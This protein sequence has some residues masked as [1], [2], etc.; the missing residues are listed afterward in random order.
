MT[1]AFV[2]KA[3]TAEQFRKETVGFFE[4]ELER[5]DR[6]V[7]AMPP[8]TKRDQ[9]IKDVQRKAIVNYRDFFR[10]LTI[11]YNDRTYAR[12]DYTNEATR[13][14]AATNA[15]LECERRRGVSPFV[16]W[17]HISDERGTA[18]VVERTG[19]V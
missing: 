8:R 11:D 17:R 19:E 5:H 13:S 6:Q 14:D 4:D 16:Q 7:N 18:Y 12:Y 9:A 1:T 2:V 3:A 10:D 15:E